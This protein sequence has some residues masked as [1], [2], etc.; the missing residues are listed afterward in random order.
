MS[1]FS[2]TPHPG[3]SEAEHKVTLFFEKPE[4][5]PEVWARSIYWA[6]H[7][8]VWV[9]NV[10]LLVNLTDTDC[11]FLDA[12]GTGRWAIPFRLN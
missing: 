4:N 1:P 2:Y 5:N 8:F 10:V 7:R 3:R 12:R 9:S 11:L 6:A